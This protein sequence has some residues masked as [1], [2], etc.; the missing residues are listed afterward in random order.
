[1]HPN[2]KISIR[3]LGRIKYEGSLIREGVT[4]DTFTGS[5][6]Y[7]FD[8]CLRIADPDTLDGVRKVKKEP[9]KGKVY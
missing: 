1:M 9:D 2:E 7:V 6:R 5:F 4:V 8:R 3:K